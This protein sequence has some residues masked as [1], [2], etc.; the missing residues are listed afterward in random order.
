[1][2]DVAKI[3]GD[4]PILSRTVYNRPLVYLD[5]SATTQKPRVVVDS[6]VREYYSEN[7]NVHRGVHFLSQQATDLYEQARGRVRTFINA[8]SDKEIVFT[9]GTTES[10]N[11]VASSF[12]ERF[13][14]EGDEV[15]ISAMEHH[16]NIVPW[17]LLQ[18]RKGIR[19]RVIPINDCGE[20][21]LDEYEKL[22]NKRTRIVAV[23]HVSNVLGTVNPVKQ[24]AA[25]AHAH[26]VPVLVDGAQS[27]PHI[28]VDVQDMDCDFFVFSGHKVYG[29]TGIGVLYGKESLLNELPPY[30]GGGEMIKNVH[31]EHTEYEDAPLRFEAG[32]PDYVGA[33]ALAAAI[34]YVSV[35]GMENIAAHEHS[36]LAYATERMNCIPGM[37][38]FGQAENKSAVL[39]FVVGNI[40]PLDLG[41]LLDRFGVAVRT[42]HHCAQP[43]MERMGV[44]SMAR[45][46]F[47]L[48]NTREEVDTLCES[49]ERI[50]K[51][52]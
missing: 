1:M 22:F 10:L 19:L 17:Q 26:G 31:F 13:M 52:F 21:L 30:Q 27:V 7:A 23:T 5:N 44:Q 35:L 38:I 32:T 49:I 9:R 15:I 37:R 28:A 50:T 45:A 39:S 43:L 6:I 20:L 3:R 24:I 18:E 4:F 47:A 8:R 2:F 48:Y 11:L 46:S 29:P 25:V 51:M 16:S 36:L 34:D 41:T 12:G 40:H 42:G 33:H 14:G